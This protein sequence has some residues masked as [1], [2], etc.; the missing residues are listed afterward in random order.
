ML[1]PKFMNYL[2][3]FGLTSAI[4]FTEYKIRAFVENFVLNRPH[5]F[6]LLTV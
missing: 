1:S 6:L 5:F 3:S 2:V 4:S